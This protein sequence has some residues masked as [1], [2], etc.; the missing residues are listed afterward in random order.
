MDTEKGKYEGKVIDHEK[1][2][3]TEG[4]PLTSNASLVSNLTGPNDDWPAC[5]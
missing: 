2:K 5:H 1:E 4:H 3:G